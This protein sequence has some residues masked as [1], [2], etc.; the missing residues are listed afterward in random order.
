[1]TLFGLYRLLLHSGWM[2]LA[3]Q[4]DLRR[5]SSVHLQE[6]SRPLKM[7]VLLAAPGRQVLE[8]ILGAEGREFLLEEAEEIVQGQAR[9][10]GGPPVPLNLQPPAPLKEW[11]VYER[12][13]LSGRTGSAP[14]G[15]IKFIWEPAR[16]GWAFTL[17][18]AYQLTGD[19]RYPEEFWVRWE[20]FTDGNPA[21]KGPNWVSA[22]EA[23]L[24]I[25]AVVFAGQVFRGSHHSTPERGRGW[26]RR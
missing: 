10:F 23:A 17:A 7:E 15:D 18:R 14:E 6:N 8:Q 11:D 26:H 21:Y 4:R 9:L 25:L 16:F 22:Q 13:E 24:R 12:G 2:R 3:T 19:E 5:V 20:Q 1:M